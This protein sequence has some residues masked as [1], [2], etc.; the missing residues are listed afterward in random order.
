MDFQKL[1]LF[2]LYKHFVNKKIRN[3]IFKDIKETQNLPTFNEDFV[4]KSH[5]KLALDSIGDYFDAYYDASRYYNTELNTTEENILPIGLVSSDAFGNFQFAHR[6]FAEFFIANF[7]SR[8]ILEQKFTSKNVLNIAMQMFL[9]ILNSAY[10]DASTA[11]LFLESSLQLFHH[12][13]FSKMKKIQNA[14]DIKFKSVHDHF[15]QTLSVSNLTLVNFI[16]FISIHLATN[17]VQIQTFWFSESESFLPNMAQ[18]GSLN[19]TKHILKIAKQIF[20]QKRLK[21]IFE[22]TN[23]DNCGSILCLAALNENFEVFKYLAK[24]VKIMFFEK[25]EK[26]LLTKIIPMAPNHVKFLR[27]FQYLKSNLNGSE[28]KM[29]LTKYNDDNENIFQQACKT[30]EFNSLEIIITEIKSNSP[31]ELKEMLQ[32]ENYHDYTALMFAME[33]KSKYFLQKVLN[34]IEEHFEETELKYYLTCSH[35]DRGTAFHVASFLQTEKGFLKVKDF[36]LKY[37]GK[38]QMKKIMV[39][40]DKRGKNV[41][42]EWL[43]EDDNVVMLLW[44]FIRELFDKNAANEILLSNIH[45][46]GID[47][48]SRNL[49]VFLPFILQTCSIEEKH[50]LILNLIQYPRLLSI[51]YFQKLFESSNET[52]KA[53]FLTELFRTRNE[54][55]F[56]SMNVVFVPGLF[57]FL[58]QKSS[59]FLSPEQVK[60]ALFIR[61]NE[62]SN[63]LFEYFFKIKNIIAIFN[64]FKKY[65]SEQDF[66]ELLTQSNNFDQT[67]LHK[68]YS[69]S[70]FIKIKTVIKIFSDNVP[71][72]EKR[73]TFQKQSSDMT[74]FMFAALLSSQDEIKELWKHHEA[75]FSCDEC[76]SILRYENDLGKTIL[77][78]AI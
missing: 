2:S 46:K 70:M 47:A 53:A 52:L 66:I 57:E 9:D 37:L 50:A 58:V 36:F 24:E 28:W 48:I 20:N 5:E 12:K 23:F 77:H 7:I 33:N 29:A 4:Y 38:D 67:L 75:V 61:T 10:V 71:E 31:L 62:V 60:G 42:M 15:F 16:E 39:L 56:H 44:D 54:N 51:P 14:F 8:E 17:E 30:V 3:L 68:V 78:Y 27:A 35:D 64:T 21:N 34:I 45:N 6:T 55:I 74:P 49:H 26:E 41:L 22:Y 59:S 73:A 40:K 18:F 43:N 1:N 72:K 13:D 69:F 11:K 65:L 19:V 63:L 76:R 25:G 32:S